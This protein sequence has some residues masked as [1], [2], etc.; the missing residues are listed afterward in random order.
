M[1]DIAYRFMDYPED[2]DYNSAELDYP[3]TH[4]LLEDTEF[5]YLVD[6]PVWTPD[7]RVWTPAQP[8]PPAAVAHRPLADCCFCLSAIQPADAIHC[9]TGCGNGFHKSCVEAYAKTRC[10]LCRKETK[11]K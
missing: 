7:E 1:V 9:H 11:F 8:E 5:H 10:P 2:W 4:D 6:E 3:D